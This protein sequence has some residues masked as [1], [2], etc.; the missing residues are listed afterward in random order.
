MFLACKF[1]RES[2]ALPLLLIMASER[3]STPPLQ[4]A[5][6]NSS[7]P[8]ASSLTPEQVKRIVSLWYGKPFKYSVHDWLYRRSTGLK[9]KHSA[10]SEKPKY[11]NRMPPRPSNAQIAATSPWARNA[12]TL[13]YRPLMSLRH[14]EM[15]EVKTPQRA[16]DFA[17]WTISNR[18]GTSPNTSNMTSVR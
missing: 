9:R 16:A 8:P 5:P 3:P 1:S 14:S 11:A 12:H 17:P 4:S 2:L 6:S 13:L 10:T 15:A 7:V 18:R